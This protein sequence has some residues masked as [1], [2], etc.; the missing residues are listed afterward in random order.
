[1]PISSLSGPCGRPV[2]LH[3]TLFPSS[4]LFRSHGIQ[5]DR[6]AV[7]FDCRWMHRG[8]GFA[9]SL[10]APIR[11]LFKNSFSDVPLTSK[12]NAPDT[13]AGKLEM[14]WANNGVQ[15][16]AFRQMTAVTPVCV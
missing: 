15:T 7:V 16:P 14:V 2:C 11:A 12:R 5:V 6:G 10:A 4:S 13:V 3:S 1:M 9:R 8:G